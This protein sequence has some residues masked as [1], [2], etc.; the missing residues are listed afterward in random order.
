MGWGDQKC[1]KSQN[2]GARMFD[3]KIGGSKLQI[4][5][6]TGTKTAIKLKK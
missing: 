1:K 5:Q 3:F 2:R 6:N 4:L